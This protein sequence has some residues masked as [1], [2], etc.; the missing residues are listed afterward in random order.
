M[1]LAK[2]TRLLSLTFL[3]FS[4]LGANFMAQAAPK[5]KVIIFDVN[6]TLLDLE[7]MRTSIG[8]ALDGQEELTTLWFSTMLHHSL[9]TT[10]TGDYQDFGKIGVAALMMVAQN[11]DIEITEEQAVTAIKTPLLSLPAHPDVKAGLKALKEQGFKL[12]SL[13]NS[14]NKGVETQFKN[15]G[16]TDYF[17]KRMSIEDIKVYKPDLRAYAWALE[18]LNIKPEE[19]LMVAAHGWDVAGAKAAGLQ[20]AFVA[21]PGKALYPLAQKP[22]Y[23]VK[24]LS[25]LVEILK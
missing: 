18:Q 7:T 5:P 8:E 2:R 14:S 21:R 6:E 13:T 22:D 19:A 12:V 3:F 10:V 24:D 20:T 17:D 4:L 15:A 11:N 23:V 25:E 16:L 9:V 1:H